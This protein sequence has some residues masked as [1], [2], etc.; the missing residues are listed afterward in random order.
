[1]IDI[2]G[3]SFYVE[4]IGIGKVIVIFDVGMGDDLLVWNKVVEE[5]L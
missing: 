2:G 1:M 5:V 4:D 3:Y